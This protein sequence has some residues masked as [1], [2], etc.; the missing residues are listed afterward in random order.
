MIARPDTA[1][2]AA[3]CISRRACSCRPNSLTGR[4]PASALLCPDAAAR[5]ALEATLHARGADPASGKP[6]TD[7]PSSALLTYMATHNYTAP[8]NW[9]GFRE[10]TEK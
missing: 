2:A 10:L 8:R 7:G 4:G 9:R 1:A 5:A 3:A 6:A